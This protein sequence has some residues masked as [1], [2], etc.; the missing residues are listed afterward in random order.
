MDNLKECDCCKKSVEKINVHGSA[1]GAYTF[2]YCE[3]CD[4]YHTEP[5]DVLI[6]MVKVNKCVQGTR[7]EFI[8]EAYHVY[9][10][11]QYVN[12]QKFLDDNQEKFIL[13]FD[14]DR[15]YPTLVSRFIRDNPPNLSR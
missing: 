11:G 9:D 2:G 5:K 3:E 15:E 1:L 10:N 6:R 12:M 8:R 14:I 13:E 4:K 7:A